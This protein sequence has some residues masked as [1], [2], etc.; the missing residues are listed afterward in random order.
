MVAAMALVGTT[1]DGQ[2]YPVIAG[3][4]KAAA[5]NLERAYRRLRTVDKVKAAVA[6]LAGSLD[7]AGKAAL[8]DGTRELARALAAGKHRGKLAPHHL[9]VLAA[10]VRVAGRASGDRALADLAVELRDGAVRGAIVDVLLG[11]QTG[12]KPAGA[13]QLATILDDEGAT[14][15]VVLRGALW[16]LQET[17]PKQ[18]SAR[19][20]KL[21]VAARAQRSGRAIKLARAAL[22]QL[23]SFPHTTPGGRERRG[24]A[25]LP[26]VAPLVVHPNRELASAAQGLISHDGET[27]LAFLAWVLAHDV[28]RKMIAVVDGR[29]YWAS[30]PS[31]GLAPADLAAP[32]AALLERALAKRDRASAG[33]LTRAMQN[34]GLVPKDGAPPERGEEVARVG[35]EGGPPLL[36][37]ARH[38]AAWGGAYAPEPFDSGN[39]DYERGCDGAAPKLLAIGDG[40]G[41]ILGGQSA[42]AYAAPDGLFLHTDGDLT[43]EVSKQWKKLGTLVVDRGGV[44]LLDS[45]EAGA[46]KHAGVNRKK[47]ALAAG[48]YRVDAHRPRGTSSTLEAVRLVLT[49]PR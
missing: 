13:A 14:D 23:D 16:G 34:L 25:W 22:D 48:S 7:A 49:A 35:T 46:G 27:F 11:W 44:V 45:L 41:L 5:T 1:R 12:M 3:L 6:K 17:S 38:L 47:V 33:I 36:V 19:R 20:R 37:P 32:L 10:C 29:I 42:A 15:E 4:S 40:H 9:Q 8:I 39:S 2:P 28:S 30:L 26:D 18:A 24:R 31:S 43:H 21:L